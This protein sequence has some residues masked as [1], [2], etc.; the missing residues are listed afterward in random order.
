MTSP[1]IEAERLLRGF[2]RDTNLLIAGRPMRVHGDGPVA[3]S[4]L[5]MLAGMGA[6]LDLP[7]SNTAD[8]RETVVFNVGDG[9][10]TL[11]GAPLS[12]RGDAAGR[13]DFA[14]AHMP[15]STALAEQMAADGTVEG[16][17]IGV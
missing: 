3:A 16:L 5:S 17:R 10:I 12:S 8:A 4:L 6:R 2:A 7:N 14:R 15:V 1:A 9:S 11:G 13:L